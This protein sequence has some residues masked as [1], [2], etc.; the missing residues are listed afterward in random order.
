MFKF[1]PILLTLFSVSALAQ[2]IPE[3]KNPF[4]GIVD[5]YQANCAVQCTAPFTEEVIFSRASKIESVLLTAYK[6]AL[7]QAASDQAQIWGDTI[8]EGDYVSF[9]PTRLDEVKAIFR[10]GE[11]VGFRILYSEGA[12][13][14][15]QCDYDGS[16]KSLAACQAGRISE[17]SFV[18]RQF[19]ISLTDGKAAANFQQGI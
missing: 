5:D 19:D 16:Q 1:L 11:I 6:E 15:A 18:S 4:Y 8:L 12:W 17:G 9:G 14:T 7:E 2:S 13:F 3:L 10:S